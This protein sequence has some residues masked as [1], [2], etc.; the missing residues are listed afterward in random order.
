[1]LIFSSPCL[2]P[3]TV[4]TSTYTSQESCLTKRSLTDR[5][6][7]YGLDMDT[8]EV[9]AGSKHQVRGEG[10]GK[11]WWS[12]GKKQ[13]ISKNREVQEGSE[14]MLCCDVTGQTWSCTVSTCDTYKGQIHILLSLCDSRVGIHIC[15]PV[16]I[17]LGVGGIHIGRS[18]W[19]YLACVY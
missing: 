12:L 10:S 3:T 13:K 9:C 5:H 4:F 18:G 8:A 14:T 1:M 16:Y 11:V 2:S 15:F 19:S 6:R 17:Y 7:K